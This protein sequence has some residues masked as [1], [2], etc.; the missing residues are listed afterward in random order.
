MRRL[1]SEIK[2]DETRPSCGQCLSYHSECSYADPTIE[3]GFPELSGGCN[4]GPYD[5]R[6]SS[7]TLPAQVSG[8]AIFGNSLASIAATQ[9]WQKET[10]RL[11]YVELLHCFHNYTVTT[12]SS[13][14]WQRI[15]TAKTLNLIQ[16]YPFFSHAIIAF[17]ASHLTCVSGRSSSVS[18]ATYHTQ[19]ALELYGERLHR[20]RDRAE[21]DAMLA[22][23]FMLTALFY[24][25]HDKLNTTES[26]ISPIQD[27]TSKP[28]W[29]T[30]LSGP[31]LLLQSNGHIESVSESLWLPF[32]RESQY[33]VGQ[34]R[35]Q[36]GSGEQLV[37]LLTDL[38]M[39]SFN[40][41]SSM[42]ALDSTAT[43]AYLSALDV[44]NPALRRHFDAENLTL[45][46]CTDVATYVLLMTFPSRMNNLFIERL[47]A[48]DPLALLLVGFWLALLSKLDHSQWWCLQRA[49]TEGSV[50]LSY[51]D[52]TQISNPKLRNAVYILSRAY[53][54]S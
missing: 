51:L 29:S 45:T 27:S 18:A 9:G 37:T 5:T 42:P 26:W 8:I 30:V 41:A 17:T 2:C 14:T 11:T 21:M 34:A 43:N 6:L 39:E 31:T 4:A 40:T 28:H 53:S 3:H 48:R 33:L 15:L 46:P 7:K 35:E 49:L 23:C 1:I 36:P 47:S 13:P 20:A 38:C 24:L 12:L 19:K 54:L 50:V 32:T 10:P 25:S 22:A 44:L 52:K 16:T